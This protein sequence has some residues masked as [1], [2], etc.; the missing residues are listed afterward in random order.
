MFRE[1]AKDGTNTSAKLVYYTPGGIYHYF[2][3]SSYNWKGPK[4]Y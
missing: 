2:N 3:D 4:F 1:E